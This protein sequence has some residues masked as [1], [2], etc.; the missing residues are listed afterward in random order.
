M[1]QGRLLE[2]ILLVPDANL[3]IP[4]LLVGVDSCRER[5]DAGY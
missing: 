2:I 5:E 3:W 4:L 1:V